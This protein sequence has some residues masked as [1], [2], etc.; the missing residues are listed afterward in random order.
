M[1]KFYLIYEKKH[2]ATAGTSEE[3]AGTSSGDSEELA[4]L[5]EIKY[6]CVC[7]DCR[8]VYVYKAPDGSSFGTKNLHNHTK[9]CSD[10]SLQS[11][12]SL[13]QCL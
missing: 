11:Q 8:R 13:R 1:K 9:I 2:E 12:L 3:Q 6:F 7:F 5:Q 4:D 10:S